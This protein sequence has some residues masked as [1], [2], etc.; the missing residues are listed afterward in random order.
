VRTA[1]ISHADCLKHETGYGHPEMPARLYAIEDRLIEVQLYY[2]LRHIE[3][4]EATREQL[5]RVHDATY[6]DMLDGY[7]SYD[8]LHY[9]DPDTPVGPH[10]LRAARLAAGALIQ[11]VDIVMQREMDNAFCAIRPPGHHAR[12]RQAMGFCIYNNVAVGVAHALQEYGLERVSILDFDVHHGNGTEEMFIDDPRVMVC[13]CFQ[14]PFFPDLPFVNDGERIV[15]APLLANSGS[16]EFRSV[17]ENRFLPALEQ[18]RPQLLFISAGFDAHRDDDMSAL[19]FSDE[20]YAW[21]TRHAVEVA[22]RHAGNRIVSALEG[23]YEPRSLGRSVE[24][25]LRVLMDLHR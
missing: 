12:P 9:L 25:H 17:V 22:R 1:Y 21:V 13:S 15:C 3:A 11:A 4:I 6:L 23:G 14:H 16:A 18:F 20:D 19:N 2:L 5:L 8:G 10:S 7:T 24:L